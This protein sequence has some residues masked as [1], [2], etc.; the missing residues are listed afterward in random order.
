MGFTVGDNTGAIV[1]CLVVG[2]PNVGAGEEGGEIVS[3][4]TTATT[5]RLATAT[6]AI[7]NELVDIPHAPA[8]EEDAPFVSIL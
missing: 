6:P 1:G 4:T 2:N 5:T 3:G 7:N 8:E